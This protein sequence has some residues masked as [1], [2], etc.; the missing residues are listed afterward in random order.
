MNFRRGN[1]WASTA[2]S[3]RARSAGVL[4]RRPSSRFNSSGRYSAAST[5]SAQGRGAKGKRTF[6]ASTTHLCPHTHTVWLRVERQLSR[7]RP[8]PYTCLPLCCGVVSSTGQTTGSP[9]GTRSKTIAA[10]TFPSG[11]GDQR[12]REKTRW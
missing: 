1:Q 5:G 12:A 7:W 6:T 10:S 9:C 4:C 11:H 8:L 3:C 2:T